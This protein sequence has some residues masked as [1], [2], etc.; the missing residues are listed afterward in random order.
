MRLLQTT[1]QRLMNP[2]LLDARNKGDS[3]PGEVVQ[4]PVMP[5]FDIRKYLERTE[6]PKPAI[7][8][9]CPQNCAACK[10]KNQ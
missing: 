1:G 5:N 8:P 4:R 7:S 6:D 9:F 10:Q 2:L 3:Q